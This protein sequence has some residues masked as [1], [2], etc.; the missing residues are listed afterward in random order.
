MRTIAIAI[1]QVFARRRCMFVFTAF[2]PT[3]ALLLFYLP[4][5]LTPGNSAAFQLSLYRPIDYAATG[6][7]A[8]AIALTIAAHCYLFEQTRNRLARAG[9]VGG[10]AVGGFAGVGAALFATA[11]C[12][13]CIA[14]LF[15][16]LGT[17]AVLSLVQHRTSVI[18]V[19]LLAMLASLSAVSRKIVRHC[20]ACERNT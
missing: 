18:A 19:A 12:S 3:T 16:F 14:S 9:S 10:A 11:T 17:G 1:R 15:G 20:A 4:V 2:V 5:W 13:W 7:L 8:L 6:G